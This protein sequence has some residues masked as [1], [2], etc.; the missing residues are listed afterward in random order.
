[1]KASR[2]PTFVVLAPVPGTYSFRARLKDKLGHTRSA[3]T[4]VVAMEY[5]PQP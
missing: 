5:A 3:N 2:A 4:P 1:V